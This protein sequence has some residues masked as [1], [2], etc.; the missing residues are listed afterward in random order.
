MRKIKLFFKQL[1]C[2]HGFFI[3]YPDFKKRVEIYTCV[4]C[5]KKKYIKM[6]D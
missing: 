3:L 6:D 1:F 5:D 2:R 4:F